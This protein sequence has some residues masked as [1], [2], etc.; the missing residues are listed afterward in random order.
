MKLQVDQDRRVDLNGLKVKNYGIGNI[1]VFQQVARSSMYSDPYRACI[2]EYLSNGIDA[3]RERNRI[4]PTFEPSRNKLTVHFN[5]NELRISDQGVGISPERMES[6]FASYYGSSKRDSDDE[7]GGFGL[8][9]KTAFADPN[10]DSFTV[11]T[12]Y[13]DKDGVKRRYVTYHFINASGLTSYAELS[14]VEAQ[15][16]ELGTTIILPID[17]SDVDTYK[18]VLARLCRHW[19]EKPVVRGIQFD[20]EVVPTL[21]SGDEWLITNGKTLEV[22]IEGIPY[23][24][25]PSQLPEKYAD[26]TSSGAVLFF[27]TGDL[28]ITSTRE[29]L[30]YRGDTVAKITER[31]DDIITALETVAV[32]RINSLGLWEAQ[33]FVKSIKPFIRDS[34][35][36]PSAVFGSSES[37]PYGIKVSLANKSY[38][39]FQIKERSFLDYSQKFTVLLNRTKKI[40]EGRLDS[41]FTKTGTGTNVY[42]ITVPNSI[43]SGGVLHSFTGP[44]GLVRFIDWLDSTN[45]G[46]RIKEVLAEAYDLQ[47]WPISDEYKKERAYVRK[48]FDKSALREHKS[49]WASIEA[50]ELESLKSNRNVYYVLVD[51]IKE[52]KGKPT[53]LSARGVMKN[54]VFVALSRDQ[55]GSVPEA[56]KP[57]WST[58]LERKSNQLKSEKGKLAVVK[59]MSVVDLAWSFRT[60]DDVRRLRSPSVFYRLPAGLR[61][62]VRNINRNSK[63][64]YFDVSE[65]FPVLDV[66]HHR[67]TLSKKVLV[68]YR[69]PGSL[70]DKR[71][72]KIMISSLRKKLQDKHKEAILE[73]ESVVKF[74]KRNLTN[75]KI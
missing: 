6:G 8:G 68:S 37:L 20:W 60:C 3:M 9:C 21:F 38:G 47:S 73:V 27:N 71:A 26:M 51:S 33:N 69:G 42:V 1:A 56:W 31:L 61:Q 72:F 15:E 46:L 18:S 23:E 36:V 43:H 34:D 12:V 63:K 67:G 11:D 2:Q 50:S 66:V 62:F 55:I 35:M 58:L 7:I 10:R 53:G 65:Q 13:V 64:P 22:V 70:Y 75:I 32:S 74:A 39:Y 28:S 4:D 24:V 44:T 17:E 54:A 45:P 16:E 52:S 29:S 49:K 25:D 5:G 40:S 14:N 48:K 19:S 59:S 57:Y 41:F 30:D